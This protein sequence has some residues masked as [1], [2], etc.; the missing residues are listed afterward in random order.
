MISYRRINRKLTNTFHKEC[1]QKQKKII[2]DSCIKTFVSLYW[3][4]KSL[5]RLLIALTRYLYF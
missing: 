5:N 4:N 2:I 3:N 1:L